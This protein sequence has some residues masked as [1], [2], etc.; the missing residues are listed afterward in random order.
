V[1]KGFGD[2]PV[3]RGVDLE[4][5]A[6]EMLAIVG[7]SG[8]GKTVLM[9]TIIAHHRPEAGNVFAADHEL[10]SAPL[11][12]VFELSEE[13]LDHLRR[14]WAVV[15][16]KNALFSGSVFENIGVWLRE[17]G[18]FE[19]KEIKSRARI[20]LERVGFE[21]DD[22][23]LAKHRDEL[24]GGMAKRVAV[25]RAVAMD[26][27]LMIFDEPTT[28]LDPALGA[29]IHELIRELHEQVLPSGVPRTTMIISHDKD[30]LWRLR[31]RVVMLDRGAVH[32]DGSYEEFEASDSP[33][34]RPYFDLMPELNAR[35]A[36]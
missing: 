18:G 3:I 14:H 2:H 9:Q 23:L 10:E 20:A 33:I 13:E 22:A 35:P 30:L 31:P 5:H 1:H 34:V 24:S 15:F 28:G 7:G 19:E 26:P 29:Q 17:I 25:A 4:V 32:M 36:T 12:D 16:Q 27:I 21:P 8:C 11:V 6:G